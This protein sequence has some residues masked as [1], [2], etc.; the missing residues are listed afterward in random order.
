MK[1][2]ETSIFTAATILL[3][4]S[5]SA[6]AGNWVINPSDDGF[7][8]DTGFVATSSYLTCGGNTRGIVEFP[9]NVNAQIVSASLS[10]N[11]YSLPIFGQTI[12]LYGYQSTD[13]RLTYSDY[14]S[15]IFLGDWTLPPL[16]YGQDAYFDVTSF[17]KTVTTSY[18]GFNLRTEGADGFSSLEYNYGHPSQLSVYTVPEPATVLLLAAGGIGLR[19]R[20]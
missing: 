20:R 19:K 18:V 5:G 8:Y 11:P 1:G 4:L 10:V 3:I 7:I 15:G 13:G 17:L 2:K 12:H 6:Y 9:L 16:G 14:A